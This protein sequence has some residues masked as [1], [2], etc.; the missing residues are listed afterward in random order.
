MDRKMP[1]SSAIPGTE[2]LRYA[3]TTASPNCG[4]ALQV[5][6]N[7][8]SGPQAPISATPA[9]VRKVRSP[10]IRMPDLKIEG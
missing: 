6:V 8:K 10:V 3:R 2:V 1:R 4:A 7:G 9:K 5:R